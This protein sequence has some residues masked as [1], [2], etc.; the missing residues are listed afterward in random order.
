M[1]VPQ[2]F[3]QQSC[4]GFTQELEIT[5]SYH[6]FWHCSMILSKRAGCH[7]FQLVA[8]SS[9]PY[10]PFIERKHYRV[11]L[12]FLFTFHFIYLQILVQNLKLGAWLFIKLRKTT[13][14]LNKVKELLFYCNSK[15]GVIWCNIYS[16]Y[17]E[18]WESLSLFDLI[19]ILT[20][21]QDSLIL[22]RTFF[23]TIE[24][25]SKYYKVDSSPG[26]QSTCS[27]NSGISWPLTYT[28]AKWFHLS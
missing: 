24:Q 10:Q 21:G 12:W 22:T 5:F 8:P 23:L 19:L 2:N 11:A 1:Q 25:G 26:T 17:I 27:V 6:T 4:L 13:L 3:L 14:E 9:A 15:V 20:A 28:V 16:I 18:D 7:I